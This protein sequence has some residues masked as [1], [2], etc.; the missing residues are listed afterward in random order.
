MD[1]IHTTDN[2]R[3]W[4]RIRSLT[5]E[6]GNVP[7][8][9]SAVIAFGDGF[10][11]TTRGYDNR[12]RLHVTDAQ[13][14]VLRQ[15]DLTATYPFIASHV[16]R[17]RLFARDGKVYLMGRNSTRVALPPTAEAKKGEPAFR[18]A[19][20]LCLFRLDA[21]GVG[22]ESYSILDNADNKNVTDGYYAMGYF[23]GTGT[24]TRFHVI[25]Y[26]ALDRQPPSILHLEYNWDDVR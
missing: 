13:F 18:P 10:L 16:G 12:E 14:H 21:S 22:V 4:K 9:E 15:A 1:V 24:D 11:V 6:F 7:I 25:T 23:R 8:N 5:R 19:M 2:G 20:Q 17:P 26:K 3:T